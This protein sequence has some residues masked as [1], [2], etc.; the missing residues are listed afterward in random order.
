MPF[1]HVGGLV[2]GFLK[3]RGQ[4]F[5][6]LRQGQI[7][8]EAAQLGGPLPGLEHGTAGAADGLRAIRL[9]KAYSVGRQPVQ[10]GGD[11][12]RL[13]H[14]AQR[15]PALL[16]SKIKKKVRAHGYSSLNARQSN[17]NADASQT[18]GSARLQPF[19]DAS[20]NLSRQPPVWKA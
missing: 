9:L 20:G 5:H 2:A 15:V 4:G 12:Q 10:T 17:R 13:T 14:A 19:A 11:G 18:E 3:G 8:A 6:I 1:A 16:I 7:V